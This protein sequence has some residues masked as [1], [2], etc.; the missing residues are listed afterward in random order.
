MPVCVNWLLRV[1]ES[2][3]V[4]VNVY[5]NVYVYVMHKYLCDCASVFVD[6]LL[7]L[8]KSLFLSPDI[9]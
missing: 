9:L 7:P 2:T 5:V 1:F 8:N 3:C 4:Y 6:E